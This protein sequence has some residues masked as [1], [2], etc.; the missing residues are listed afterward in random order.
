MTH[1]RRKIQEHTFSDDFKE[2][3]K[4]D[5]WQGGWFVS[6]Q[7]RQIVKLIEGVVGINVCSNDVSF[8]TG[9]TS[10]Y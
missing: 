1:D 8:L 9:T 5:G 10:S 7:G 2:V 6:H 3:N 4:S